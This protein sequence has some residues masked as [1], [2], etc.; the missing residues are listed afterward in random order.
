MSDERKFERLEERI[1]EVR[2]G[3]RRIEDHLRERERFWSRVSERALLVG[4]ML[5][6]AITAVAVTESRGRS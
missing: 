3:V 6:A 1:G 2:S 4:A 5:F